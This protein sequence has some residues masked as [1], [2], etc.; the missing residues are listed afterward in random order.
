MIEYT[1]E[2]ISLYTI[3][4][5]GS[6]KDIILK[7]NW[8]Y[9]ASEGPHVADVYGVT[10]IDP[11]SSDT[12]I[13]FKDIKEEQIIEW[14]LKKINFEDLKNEVNQKLEKVKTPLIKEVRT[15]W[16]QA[17]RPTGKEEYILIF[18]NDPSKQEN[19]WGPLR[20]SSERINAGLE[21]KGMVD[22]VPE[23]IIMY[24]KGLLPTNSPLIIN[25]SAKVYKV[26]D[27]RIPAIDER[28]EILSR[29]SWDLRSGQAVRCWSVDYKNFKESKDL[30][31]ANVLKYIQGTLFAGFDYSFKG[32]TY[33]IKIEPFSLS[34]YNLKFLATED[35]EIINW[36]LGDEW[37]DM[38][39]NEFKDLMKEVDGFVQTFSDFEKVKFK[40]I[41]ACITFEQLKL[42][43][44]GTSK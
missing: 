26:V 16:E 18:N 36:K 34:R 40:E 39:K 8:R 42:I 10:E 21:T 35:N 28:F 32:K 4:E 15:P 13:N 17:A 11:P 24:R 5:Q 33:D 6:L 37:V 20:W 1:W 38:S 23:D 2:I 22:R 14:L 29:P 31:K 41:D 19:L 9:Q 27:L 7:I 44:I 25:D 30:L 43:E 12:F 3:P